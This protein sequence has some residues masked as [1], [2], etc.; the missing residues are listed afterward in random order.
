MDKNQM[1]EEARDLY[2]ELLNQ[3]PFRKKKEA[4]ERDLKLQK[5][6]IAIQ[7]LIACGARTQTGWNFEN[8]FDINTFWPNFL[9]EMSKDVR[10][11]IEVTCDLTK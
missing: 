3:G 4:R 10:S 11:H 1:L 7:C 5:V 8:N 9:F 6:V 2:L